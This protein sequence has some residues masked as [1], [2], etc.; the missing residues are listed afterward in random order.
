MEPCWSSKSFFFSPVCHC[1]SG[2]HRACL[3][4]LLFPPPRVCRAWVH[5]H[6]HV[7]RH[8][9]PCVHM[10]IH[11]SENRHTQTHGAFQLTA[12]TLPSS[13]ERFPA[14]QWYLLPCSSSSHLPHPSFMTL[15]QRKVR[16]ESRMYYKQ[17]SDLWPD[18]NPPESPE[19]NAEN[20]P[21]ES[22]RLCTQG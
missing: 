7:H 16:L 20:I 1:S 4:G 6:T 21:W 5:A 11:T 19:L 18:T 17:V 14:H 3:S 15:T 13:S 8:T 12:V 22:T 10:C 2:Q 9:Q